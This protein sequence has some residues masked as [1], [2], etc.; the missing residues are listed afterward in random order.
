[1]AF[2]EIILE[3]ISTLRNGGLIAY[4]TEGVW[5]IGC[6]PWNEKAVE[7]LLAMKERP[8]EKG[9]IVVAANIEQIPELTAPLEQG[10]LN[11]LNSTWPGPITWLLP[12]PNQAFPGWVKGKFATVA[13]RVSAHPVVRELC[14]SFGGPIISTSANPANLPPALTM[15]EV[16]AYFADELDV[17]VPGEL[18]GQE[19]PSV[20]RDL[21]SG[22]T[23]RI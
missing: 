14:E 20:I 8:A 13:V 19:G 18:G 11:Q 10:Q 2:A 15:L 16:L 4:P 3:A 22:R 1:M 12:D 17:I 21:A 6:D 23:L 7:K 9:L 5:G